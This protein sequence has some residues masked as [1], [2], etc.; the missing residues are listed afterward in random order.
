[1]NVY[2]GI[3]NNLPVLHLYVEAPLS[4]ADL[5]MQDDPF[6]IEADW[7]GELG[8]MMFASQQGLAEILQHCSVH[9]QFNAQV[10]VVEEEGTIAVQLVSVGSLAPLG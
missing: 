4:E 6:R 7:R 10:E 5:W 3:V 9:G 1:M 2:P 8:G